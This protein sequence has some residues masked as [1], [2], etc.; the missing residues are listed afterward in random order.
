MHKM[1]KKKETPVESDISAVI[2]KGCEFEGKLCFEGTARIAGKFKGGIYTPHI[3][4]VSEGAEVEA[5]VEADTVIINGVFNG[6]VKAKTRVEL[7][8]PAI[9]RGDI[10]SPR[11]SIEDGVIFEGAVRVDQ[12]VQISDQPKLPLTDPRTS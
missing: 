5:E 7:R 2:E 9:L 4:V 8:K 11:I 10:V 3:L 1:L 6:K 12:G